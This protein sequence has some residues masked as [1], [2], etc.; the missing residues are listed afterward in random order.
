L[1]VRVVERRVLC[2]AAARA[3]LPGPRSPDRPGPP[4]P[5]LARPGPGRPAPVRPHVSIISNPMRPVP[6]LTSPPLPL[7]LLLPPLRCHS[8][9]AP[10]IASRRPAPATCR[11]A[12][13]PPAPTA[14]SVRRVHERR[15]SVGQV[16]VRGL[17]GVGRQDSERLI[18]FFEPLIG[19]RFVTG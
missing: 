6:P 12:C 18:S 4:R 19:K 15:S 13:R 2:V 1:S 5:C 7:L 9:P 8:R 14:S 16:K 17:F 11:R 3:A 10:R